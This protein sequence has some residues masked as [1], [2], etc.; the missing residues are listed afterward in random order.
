MASVKEVFDSAAQALSSALPDN[1][2]AKSEVSSVI[3]WT[4]R[5]LHPYVLSPRLIKYAL[6]KYSSSGLYDSESFA[7]LA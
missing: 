7:G 4:F 5:Y 3:Y 1:K 2:D 6:F